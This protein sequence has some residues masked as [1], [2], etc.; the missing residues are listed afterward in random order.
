[1]E[2]EEEEEHVFVFFY[3]LESGRQTKEGES[4][5][6]TA[7]NK[8][9]S[10]SPLTRHYNIESLLLLPNSSNLRRIESC[11]LNI[12]RLAKKRRHAEDSLFVPLTPS[13]SL[14]FFFALA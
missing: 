6:I 5:S 8:P 1:M 12:N 14:P 13:L 10:P 2:A 11:P 7:F 4:I 9:F 3:F